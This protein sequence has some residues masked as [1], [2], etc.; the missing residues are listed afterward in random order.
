VPSPRKKRPGVISAHVAAAW[1]TIAG[2]T[3]NVGHVTAVPTRS[4]LVACAIPPI[5]L[6]TNGLY[7]CRSIHRLLGKPGEPDELLR[8]ELLAR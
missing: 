3:R 8:P 1:A 2:C 4:R 5:T 6:Q 7:P